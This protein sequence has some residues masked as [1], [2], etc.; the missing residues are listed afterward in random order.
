MLY[1]LDTNVVSNLRR[2]T[3]N[4]QLL[5][6]LSRTPAE[7]IRIPVLAIFEIQYGIES[8]RRDGKSA[9]ADDI[10]AWLERLMNS[11]GAESILCPGVDAARL[12]A[13]MFADRALNNFLFPQPG[14]SKPKF[15]GDLIISA[16]AI[17]IEAAVVTF[18]VDDYLSIHSRYPLPGLLHPGRNEWLV[19]AGH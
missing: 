16:M 12:Q 17:T 6:W 7:A 11:R 1:L 15:G 5:S 19:R 10:E 14:A 18:D 3:P 8:L 9:K 13:R 4:G 2:Q